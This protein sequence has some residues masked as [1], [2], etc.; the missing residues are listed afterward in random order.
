MH[1]GFIRMHYDLAGEMVRSRN[2]AG[3]K[4][5]HHSMQGTS[6]RIPQSGTN[7]PV[8]KLA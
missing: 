4:E 1:P 2:I 8:R 7:T 5:E 3:G 6:T